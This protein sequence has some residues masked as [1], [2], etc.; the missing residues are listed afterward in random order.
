MYLDSD[1]SGPFSHE[2][3]CVLSVC[4]LRFSFLGGLF[5]SYTPCICCIPLCWVIFRNS[6][7]AFTV[8]PPY[9]SSTSV[10]SPSLFFSCICFS[11]LC[12]ALVSL[13]EHFKWS[14]YSAPCSLVLSS[15]YFFILFLLGTH[16][17]N[18]SNT[19][20]LSFWCLLVTPQQ[21]LAFFSFCLMLFLCL[22]NYHISSYYITTLN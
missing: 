6:S 19:Q 1:Y 21:L 18:Y 16:C 9:L 8:L 12:L 22:Y 3:L 10:F 14:L 7:C 4:N 15:Q 13:A 17:L 2:T 5:M 20:L 11:L